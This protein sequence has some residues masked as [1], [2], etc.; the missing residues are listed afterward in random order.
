MPQ[1]QPESIGFTKTKSL[2]IVLLAYVVAI[3]MGY[4]ILIQAGPWHPLIGVGVADGICTIIIFGFSLWYRNSSIYDPYWSVI[5]PFIA[6]FYIYI[7]ADLGVLKESI[8]LLAILVWAIRLTYNWLKGWGG[9]D[10]E[11]WRYVKL[12]DEHPRSYWLVSLGGVHMFPTALVFAGCTPIFYSAQVSE[13]SLWDVVALT[14][15]IL[16]ALIQYVADEQMRIFR[17]TPSSQVMDKGLWAY[18]RHPNYFGEL[19]F[20]FGIW[21]FSW[22]GPYDAIIVSSIG[23]VSMLLLFVFISIP[24]MEKEQTAK[25]PGYKD[26]QKKV[27]MLIPWG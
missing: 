24:M 25:R 10:D 19:L 14:L 1:V 23:I 18:S 6:L 15:C 20:W 26:Y 7:N 4:L 11:D 9:L 27:S 3:S 13:I 21:V 8:I 16:A 2:L 22:S 5:P 17:Q 12:A